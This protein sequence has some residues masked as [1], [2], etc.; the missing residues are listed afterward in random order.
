M[1]RGIFQYFYKTRI[2]LLVLLLSS[3]LYPIL[4]AQTKKPRQLREEVLKS[5]EKEDKLIGG[6]ARKGISEGKTKLKPVNPSAINKGATLLK[7][8][9]ADRWAYDESLDPGIQRLNGNVRFR[10]DNSL[11]FCDSA[12]FN[13]AENSFNA[14]NNVRIVQGDTLTIYGDYLNYDGN[15]RLAQLWDN[16]KLINRNTVLTTSMMHYDRN[17]DLAYYD[18]GGRVEDGNNVLTSTWGQ[19]SPSTKVALFKSNVR[20]TNP[21][22][23]LTTDTLKYNTSN[24]IAD[25]VGNSLIIHK[26]ETDIY[27]QRGWYDTENDRM[28]LLERSLVEQSDGK[29]LVGDTI[30]YDQKEKYGE[31]FSNVELNDPENRTTLTG[32]F[33]S[34]DEISSIGLATDSAL[35]IDWSGQDSLFLSADT[36]YTYKDSI[37]LDTMSYTA[38]KAFKNVRFVRKDVQGVSDSLQYTSRDSVLHMWGIPVLWSDNNQL[39]GKEIKAYMKNQELDHVVIS[40]SAIAIQKDSLGYFNQLAG[41]ELIAH[42]DTAGNLYR[43]NVNGN[44]E[45]IYFPKDGETGDYIGVNKTVS[46]YATGYLKDEK[47]DRIVLT[48]LSSG[49]MYP[50]STMEEDDLYLRDFHWFE[51]ERPVKVDDVFKKFVR[52]EPPRRPESTKKPEFPGSSDDDEP[53]ERAPANRTAGNRNTP[54]RVPVAR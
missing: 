50:L 1:L 22:T 24:S 47:I 16:V 13:E 6:E 26:D 39:K 29:T 37:E 54:E 7:L 9:H 41:K 17:I 11:L 49:V 52:V 8:E 45:T 19:Y 31:A 48:T 23:Q 25:I 34:Y 36:L 4:S 46:S 30:F 35:F 42:V 32:N 2:W 28:M 27:S 14:M 43:V 18:T 15:S 12:Y 20:M 53:G 38:M 40:R 10:Q 3:G 21:D 5:K 51:E 44:V 33:V